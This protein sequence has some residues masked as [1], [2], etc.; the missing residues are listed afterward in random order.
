MSKTAAGLTTW[1]IRD[2]QGNTLS[3]Y[4]NKSSAVNWREQHLYGSSRLG[5]WI[6][7]V[8]LATNNAFAVW[9][10]IGRKQYELTNHLGNVLAT[11]TDKRLQH[12]TSGTTIDYYNPDIATAQD[13]YAFGSLM[14]A[15]QYN[16]VANNYYRYGFNGKE[17]DNDVGKGIGNEQDYGK[18]IYDP[19]VGRF[20]SVD[21]VG[22]SYPW[23]T[24]YS[25]TGNNPIRY[26]DLDGLETANPS[27][28]HKAWNA[29][30]GD[31][32]MIRMNQFI[33]DNN[34][35]PETVISLPNETYVIVQTFV[36]AKTG[37]A[38]NAYTIFRQ[39]RKGK[40][41]SNLASKNNDDY[42]L[43]EKQFLN[44]QVIGE[45]IT[46]APFAPAGEAEELGTVLKG[47][48]NITFAFQQTVGIA[49]MAAKEITAW[50]N[51]IKLGLADA[52][53]ISRDLL[54]KGF[55]IHFQNLGGLELSLQAAEEGEIGLGY[56]SGP[57]KNV[58]DAIKVFNK[59]LKNPNF[60]AAL[61]VKL[62]ASQEALEDAT[63][64]LSNAN[65][66]KMAVDKAKEI[67]IIIKAISK[68]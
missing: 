41:F 57:G 49:K 9:D 32:Q 29:L 5:M 26:V 24:P 33:T 3:V 59:A 44:T 11:L 55:H 58:R 50:R 19:R 45:P 16:F 63:K 43:S 52:T 6:P 8:N 56:I 2:A 66:V 20:L 61:L 42:L 18:R 36:N 31:Y 1:Y 68:L 10:T 7:N 35:D 34:V 67:K 27:L 38:E 62:R 28:F 54:K 64:I 22:K 46:P 40:I 60:R 65:E 25:F 15:R 21:P 53:G 13:Y 51:E 48:K 12:T 23:F 47:S 37:L 30:M 4:D 17:N 39:S 14:P